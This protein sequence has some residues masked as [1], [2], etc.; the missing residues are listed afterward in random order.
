MASLLDFDGISIAYEP[1]KHDRQF[2][3][4]YYCRLLELYPFIKK[5]INQKYG[6]NPV[7]AK[8]ASTYTSGTQFAII[9][10]VHVDFPSRPNILTE[11]TNQKLIPNWKESF[12]IYLEDETAKLKVDNCLHNSLPIVTGLVIGLLGRLDASGTLIPDDALFPGV[13]PLR[14]SMRNLE[15]GRIIC[16]SDLPRSRIQFDF[17]KAAMSSINMRTLV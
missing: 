11:I 15:A 14:Q 5:E 9:G 17:L 13:C 3:H 12:T 10:V 7:S 16:I 2:N 4:L 8:Q 1:S 6:L